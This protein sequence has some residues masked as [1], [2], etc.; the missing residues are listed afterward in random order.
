MRRIYKGDE[1]KSLAEHRRSGGNYKTYKEREELG[2]A[3][4]KEQG[5]LCCYCMQQISLRKMRIEH[6]ASQTAHP[7]RTVDYDN[8]LGACTGGENVLPVEQQHCDVHR[9]NEPLHV[10]P[11][12]PPPTCEQL[13][14]YLANGKVTS[15]D[16]VVKKDVE[17]TLNLNA[18]H[19]VAARQKIH[20]QLLAALAR[21][22]KNGQWAPALIEAHAARWR[23]RDQEGKHREY[24]QV[25]L[26]YLEKKLKK[27]A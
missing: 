20:D 4:L 13:L 7:T 1:P 9:K 18:D 11:T 22:Q 19:L 27:K 17:T 12:Q 25:V 24:C 10:H 26:Y 8:L 6:W 21:E 23:G 5:F 15:D 2:G 14:R 3:L 16:P